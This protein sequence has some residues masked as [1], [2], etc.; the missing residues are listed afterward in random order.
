MPK[1]IQQ[2]PTYLMIKT[3]QL[4]TYF[5]I[6][7][8]VVTAPASLQ[9]ELWPLQR[10]DLAPE[11]LQD[12]A[13]KRAGEKPTSMINGFVFQV[14]FPMKVRTSIVL[15]NE[16]SK[17]NG[18]WIGFPRK[19]CRRTMFLHFFMDPMRK[20][21]CGNEEVLAS[22]VQHQPRRLPAEFPSKQ[23]I[24]LQMGPS[25]VTTINTGG[26]SATIIKA[27]HQI[28]FWF[29]S[30]LMLHALG[31]IIPSPQASQ[32]ADLCDIYSGF[33]PEFCQYADDSFQ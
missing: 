20:W 11:E 3:Y 22:T 30:G 33:G 21:E 25:L 13:G 14:S 5:A 32:S 27:K 29:V 2:E 23:R 26:S 10:V 9:R 8:G 4:N 15:S 17:L 7:L 24:T 28:T 6:V 16:L 1:K 12:L 19:T 18:Q 31:K